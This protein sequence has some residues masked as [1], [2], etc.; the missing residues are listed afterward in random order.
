MPL[1][2][3]NRCV[4]VFFI[5]ICLTYIP[6]APVAAQN[7]N[8]AVFKAAVENICVPASVCGLPDLYIT[9]PSKGRF[10]VFEDAAER[11]IDRFIR[12]NA[13]ISTGIKYNTGGSR[14]GLPNHRGFLN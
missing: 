11:T 13:S 7:G 12:E 9:R 8:Q 5:L 3:K 10:R 2:K 4:C 6:H 1:E 14:A